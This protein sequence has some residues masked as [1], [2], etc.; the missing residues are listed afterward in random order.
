[1]PNR[2]RR[3]RRRTGFALLV[4]LT[5][6]SVSIAMTYAVMHRQSVMLQ[7]QQNNGTRVTARHAAIT[8]MNVAL[9]KM[10]QSNWAG[11]D[12]A[13][14]GDLG[15]A[16]SYSVT[17]T[18]GD[19][20]LEDELNPGTPDPAHSDYS[21]WPFRVTV[22]STGSVASATSG[23]APTEYR[24]RAV[25]KL[26]PRALS[27][28]P[29]A[30]D[31]IRASTLYQYA[32]EPN[33]PNYIAAPLRVDGHV[34]VRGPLEICPTLSWPMSVRNEYLGDLAA[35]HSAA[36]GDHRMITG[37][38][39][40]PT[41]E[42]DGSDV[43]AVNTIMGLTTFNT[44]TT[45]APGWT[46]PGP[47]NTYRLYPGGEVYNVA[48][49]S[50]NLSN[51]TLGPDPDTNPAGLFYNSGDVILNGDVTIVGTVIAGWSIDL[52]GPNISVRPADLPP[53]YGSSSTVQLP[54]L[55]AGDDLRVRE[56]CQATASG[57]IAV[58]NRFD[59]DPGTRDTTFDLTGR[60]ACR[61][62][63]VEPRYTWNM[64]ETEWTSMDQ[65]FQVEAISGNPEATTY[66]PMY[67]AQ[68]G[69]SYVPTIR[70]TAPDNTVE[71]QWITDGGSI[72]A[73]SA[74]DAGL[75]WDLLNWDDGV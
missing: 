9:R 66:F 13:L 49:C 46:Y 70:L 33:Y 5:I 15:A 30:W 52:A 6:I 29:A 50:A 74:G 14:S 48:S 67:L 45:A 62:I 69:Y 38:V 59:V 60:L 4:V 23:V 21:D 56:A 28:K 53:T 31:E 24:V 42:Q 32:S 20:S 72:Y 40:W 68:H 64:N 8:G 39:R 36:M 2:S 58:W 26:V 34:H 11:V 55:I 61:Q 65:A 19:P 44:A 18:T 25:M 17:F 35:M 27:A 3:V 51:G 41:A 1:M 54:A 73:P 47:I 57:L 16:G 22:V 75:M 37:L 63:R 10:H 7:V 12:V 43:V 71:Y